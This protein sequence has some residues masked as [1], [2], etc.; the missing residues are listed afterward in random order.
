MFFQFYAGLLRNGY[1]IPHDYKSVFRPAQLKQYKKAEIVGSQA[2]PA[3]KSSQAPKQKQAPSM[4]E[5]KT[6][7]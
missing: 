1:D 2:K 5:Q 6:F 4:T 3:E 7:E